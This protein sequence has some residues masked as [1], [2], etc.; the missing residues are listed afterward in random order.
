MP[1]D[2]NTT[3]PI[4]GGTGDAQEED[5]GVTSEPQDEGVE[6]ALTTQQEHDDS[7]QGE[8]APP[9]LLFSARECPPI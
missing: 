8:R 1:Q 6:T 3:I 4:V 7:T 5:S 9:V 2:G